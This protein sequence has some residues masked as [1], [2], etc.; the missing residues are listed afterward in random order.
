MTTVSKWSWQV[1]FTGHLF[2]M[3]DGVEVSLRRTSFDGESSVWLL[4]IAED[5]EPLVQSVIGRA[6]RGGLGECRA[7]ERADGA[8]R[9][10]MVGLFA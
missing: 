10:L 2:A 4:S 9:A 6:G 1:L 3:V 8:V 7:L 5:A